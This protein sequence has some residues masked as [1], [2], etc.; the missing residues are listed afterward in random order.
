MRV[1]STMPTNDA[2]KVVCASERSLENGGYERRTKRDREREEKNGAGGTREHEDRGE[3]ERQA[4][5]KRDED[6][7]E[8]DVRKF[9]NKFEATREQDRTS[10]HSSVQVTDFNLFSNVCISRFVYRG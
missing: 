6:G 1:A 5:Y 2:S 8:T 9:F 3:S 4:E 7:I 10:R